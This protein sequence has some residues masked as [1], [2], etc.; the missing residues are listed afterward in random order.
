[1][2]SCLAVEREID[3]VVSK[4][5][6][7]T[8]SVGKTVDEQIIHIEKLK[9]ALESNSGSE[10]NSVE[11]TDLKHAT[12]KISEAIGRLATEHRDLHCMVSK[13]GKTVDRNFV[14]DFDATSREDIFI[15]PDKEHLLNEV[16]LQHLYRQGHLNISEL[17]AQESGIH[18]YKSQKEPFL[19]LNRILEALRNRD[20]KP[21]LAWAADNRQALN[22]QKSSLELQLHKLKF[23][24]LLLKGNRI[25]V[26]VYARTIFPEFVHGQ[27]KEVQ[28]LM[29]AV[30]YAGSDLSNSPYAHLLDPCHWSEIEDI[31]L[32][33]ACTLMGLSIESPLAV[34]VNAGCGALP[35][36]LNIKQVM[37]Q[38]KVSGVWNAQDELPIEIDLPGNMRFHSVFACPILRRQVSDHNPPMRLTCGHVISRDALTSLTTSHKLKCPLCPI[39]QNPND[40]RAIYF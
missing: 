4:F 24:D 15:G 1:M 9:S 25:D 2:E 8:K 20:L 17:L 18:E 27:E 10:L 6:T 13:V 26:I 29:G 37:Q 5:S 32:R 30:M 14:P 22:A 12:L 33:D 23:V 40:A 21:A 35:A 38:R 28:S 31:F 16:I 11:K 36:L 19:E 3:K 39:E 7:L 34:A